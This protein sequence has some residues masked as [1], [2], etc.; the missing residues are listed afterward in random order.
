MPLFSLPDV[1][2][3]LAVVDFAVPPRDGC[4]RIFLHLVDDLSRASL[5]Y[6]FVLFRAR[7][8]APRSVSTDTAPRIVRRSASESG[9]FNSVRRFFSLD[10]DRTKCVE[11]VFAT[12]AHS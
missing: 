11:N 10:N 2:A 4:P 7:C 6:A 3:D 12:D 8:D 9:I 1:L 5:L